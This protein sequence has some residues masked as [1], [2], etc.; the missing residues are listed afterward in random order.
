V[1]RGDRPLLRDA[2]RRSRGESQSFQIAPVTNVSE[3]ICALWT[4]ILGLSFVLVVEPSVLTN[5]PQL[6]SAVFRPR[7]FNI[8]HP[9]G[10]HELLLSWADG[11][12]HRGDMTLDFLRD[13]EAS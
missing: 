2:S 9:S 3:D 7:S 8:R 4:N 12:P 6:A 5:L 1:A 13:V 11:N 10:S